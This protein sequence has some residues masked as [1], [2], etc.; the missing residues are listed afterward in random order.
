MARPSTDSE[1]IEMLINPR[2]DTLFFKRRMDGQ[3]TLLVM[4]PEGRSS[5]A[6]MSL[7]ATPEH[8]RAWATP[9][10]ALAVAAPWPRDGQGLRFRMFRMDRVAGLLGRQTGDINAALTD[11]PLLDGFK[12]ESS[13][14]PEAVFTVLGGASMHIPGLFP[15]HGS[16]DHAPA[17]YELDGRAATFR[18]I[19]LACL[20]R[21]ALPSAAQLEPGTG[22]FWLTVGDSHH[23]YV[24][25]GPEF[26]LAGDVVWPAE[27]QGLARLAFH[28][29][30][31]EAWIAVSSTLLVVNRNSLRVVDEIALEDELRW[32]R[33]QRVECSLGGVVFSGD[34]S[35]AWVARP[36]SGDVLEIDTRTRKRRGRVPVAID[37][38]DLLVAPGRIYMQGLRNGSVGWFAART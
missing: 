7:A 23:L 27:H 18:V 31:P 24:L 25:D 29:A 26:A 4:Q 13:A 36:Y 2:G 28:P 1:P 12:T 35:T 33:G 32:Q 15:V 19:P 38:L 5:D 21:H 3:D 6:P 14:M 9:T 37:A 8:L 16:T 30:L 22:R 20:D 17:I 10:G 34:G 11:V